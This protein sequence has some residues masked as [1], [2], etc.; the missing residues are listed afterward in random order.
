MLIPYFQTLN[1]EPRRGGGWPY[2][3]AARREAGVAAQPALQV[4]GALAVSAQVDG[5]RLDVDVHQVVDDLALDVVLD[6]VDQVAAAHVDH[7]DEG[8]VPEGREGGE[9]W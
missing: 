9:G 7:L 2:L 4:V 8:E 5:A 6:A 3:S 1:A